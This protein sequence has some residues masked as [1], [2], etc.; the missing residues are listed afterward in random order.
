M[1]MH[2]TQRRGEVKFDA[3]DEERFNKGEVVERLWPQ[4]GPSILP[5]SGRKEA[6][7]LCGPCANRQFH[8][9]ATASDDSL[10]A[11]IQLDNEHFMFTVYAPLLL[12]AEPVYEPSKSSTCRRQAIKHKLPCSLNRPATRI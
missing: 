4:L 8:T 6:P 10:L 3:R 9:S 2:K 11:H 5:A 12:Q 1:A 7:R